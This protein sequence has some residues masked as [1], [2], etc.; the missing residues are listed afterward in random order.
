MNRGI[1]LTGGRR[2]VLTKGGL[3][4]P[5]NKRSHHRKKGRKD[6]SL[7][8]FRLLRLPNQSSAEAKSLASLSFLLYVIKHRLFLKIKQGNICFRF[9]LL[10]FLI[11]TIY[12]SELFSTYT[13]LPGTS[14]MKSFIL[15]CRSI[16]AYGTW[17]NTLTLYGW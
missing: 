4:E 13:V 12:F 2:I 14:T 6:V 10:L 16:I 8:R 11:I 7:C 1:K 9:K 3:C 5:V 15:Y 17:T